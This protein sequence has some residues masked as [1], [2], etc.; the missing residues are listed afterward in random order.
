[1]VARGELQVR[2]GTRD[3]K[4][5]NIARF[6]SS[7]ERARVVAGGSLR[8]AHRVALGILAG[9]AWLGGGHPAL[10]AVHERLVSRSRRARHCS[11]A[12]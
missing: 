11:E 8:V 7:P 4:T 6:L 3:P 1:M 2:E 5:D 10:K 9:R 12:P